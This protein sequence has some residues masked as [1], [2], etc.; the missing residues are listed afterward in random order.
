M[1]NIA[2]SAGTENGRLRILFWLSLHTF[3]IG[4]MLI[5]YT[6]FIFL[7]ISCRGVMSLKLFFNVLDHSINVGHNNEY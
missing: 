4:W 6:F 7:S 3:H 1:E 2:T 5:L